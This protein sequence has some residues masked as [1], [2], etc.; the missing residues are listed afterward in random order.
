M[1]FIQSSVTKVEREYREG[2]RKGD[3]HFGRGAEEVIKFVVWEEGGG[4]SLRALRS[5]Y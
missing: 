3:Y 5:L 1:E 2:K 4:Q